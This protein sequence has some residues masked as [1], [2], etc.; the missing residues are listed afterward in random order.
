[1]FVCPEPLVRLLWDTL[2][3]SVLSVSPGPNIPVQAEGVQLPPAIFCP[4]PLPCHPP[5]ALN[6]HSEEEQP[7]SIRPPKI[8]WGGGRGGLACRPPG[9]GPEESCAPVCPPIT[10]AE[11]QETSPDPVSFHSSS[12]NLK[13][14]D[15]FG[16]FFSGG[17]VAA[18]CHMRSL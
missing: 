10:Q 12:W 16:F 14:V 4:D 11:G 9:L 18:S 5:T 1:M 8:A 3:S 15:V 6:T 7:P 13:S 17:V 2:P